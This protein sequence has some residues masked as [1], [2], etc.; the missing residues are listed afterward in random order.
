MD[1]TTYII[2]LSKYTQ[3]YTRELLFVVLLYVV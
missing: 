1:S 2:D 3:K